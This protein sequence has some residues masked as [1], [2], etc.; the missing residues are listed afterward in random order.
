MCGIR[1]EY[2]AKDLLVA[3]DPLHL[4]GH[5]HWGSNSQPLSVQHLCGNREVGFVWFGLWGVCKEKKT[6]KEEDGARRERE[7]KRNLIQ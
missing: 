3:F 5:R 4:R 6:G 1:E 7:R 2:R